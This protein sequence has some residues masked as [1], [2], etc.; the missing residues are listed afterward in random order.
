MA[1]APVSDIVVHPREGDL[2]G[3]TYGRGTWI[4]NIVPL[5][6]MG[7]H[8]LTSD[9]ALLPVRSFAQRN[10]NAFG[11]FRLLGDRSPSTPN[12][13]NGM[14]IAYY[15][16]PAPPNTAAPAAAPQGGRGGGRGGSGG[17]PGVRGG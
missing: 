2:V 12:E 9:A 17:A 10:D 16:K 8:F 3:G 11:S 14:T 5:R 1:P 7:G 15:L 6:G 13:P 4:S